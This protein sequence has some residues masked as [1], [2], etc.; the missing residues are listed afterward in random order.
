MGLNGIQNFAQALFTELDN[1][2]TTPPQLRKYYA[3]QFKG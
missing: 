2:R 3:R 1:E